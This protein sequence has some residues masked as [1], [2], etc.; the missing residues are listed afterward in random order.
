MKICN[1]TAT[2]ATPLVPRRTDEESFQYIHELEVRLVELER[3]NEELRRDQAALQATREEQNIILE[4][5]GVGIAFVRNR[6]MQWSNGAFCSMF[7]YRSHDVEDAET[8]IFFPSSKEYEQF[9][10]EAYPALLSGETIV[11]DETMRRGDGTLFTARVSGKIVDQVNPAAGSIWIFV[12]ITSQNVLEAQLQKSANLL[13]TLSHQV[14]GMIYQCRLFPDGH[15]CFP[16]ASDAIHDI[17]GVTPE[18]VREDA[19]CIYALLHPDD[20]AEFDVSIRESARTLQQWEHEYRVILRNQGVRWRYGCARPENL[21]DGSI[22]W[23]G[24]VN[25]ISAQKKLEVELLEARHAAEAANRAKSEFLATMSHEIRTPMNGV[26]GMTGLLL[27][28]ELDS[29]QREFAEIVRKSGENLL[30]LINDILDYSK[31]EA[32]KLD[33]ELLD[34]DLRVTLEDTAELLALRATDAGLELIC[35]IDPAVPSYLKGDPGRLRQIITNLVGNAVKFTRQGE[36]VISTELQSEQDGWVTIRCAVRDSGIGIPESRLAAIFAP[37]TQADSSTT[38]KYGGT[39]LGLAICKQLTEMMGGEIGVTS[40]EGKGSTFWFTA[41]FEKQTAEAVHHL[42]SL[43]SAV[44]QRPDLTESRILV[45]DDN[46]TN[47][48]LLMTL[49]KH[50]GCRYELAVDGESGLAQLVDAAKTGDPFRIA[51]LDQ[52]MPGMDGTELG[53]RIK[54]DPQLSTTIMVMITSLGQRGDAGKL[55][56]I[57]FAGYLTKPVRQAQ[58]YDCLELVLAKNGA[59]HGTAQ[60]AGKMVQPSPKG[61]VTRHAV[62]ESGRSGIRILLAED[63]VINQKVAQHMLKTLGYKADVV[64]DGREALRALELINYDLVLMDCQMPEMDGFE[65]TTLI[66]CETSPVLNHRVPIIAMTAN[67]MKGDREKCLEVGMDDYL[68]K[69]VKKEELAEVIERWFINS[70]RVPT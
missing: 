69:P 11:R 21:M 23:H 53:R 59:T 2:S 22:V 51:L 34:F 43:R 57:G 13:T 15:S 46:A 17:Y 10:L 39:G 18:E 12:D 65:A 60:L 47:R 41:R 31:I 5:A 3:Q 63:N 58:L 16:Y 33:M 64:A 40:E 44:H 66:R 49:L 37:F 7:G 42:A 24:F 6:R 56:E 55:E 14:P 50:W 20:K 48:K 70:E 1:D 52:E 61:I 25:D 28:T 67:A 36:V 38:R 4:N 19:A 32:G 45:V 30:S 62:A 27:D 35:Q 29:E 8:L 26:I 68:A 54:S 9:G